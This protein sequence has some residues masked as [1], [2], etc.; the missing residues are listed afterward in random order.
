MTS[1]DYLVELFFKVD[2]AVRVDVACMH[3]YSQ[4]VPLQQSHRKLL[5]LQQVLALGN[6]FDFQFF[7]A[8]LVFEALLDGKVNLIKH[9]HVPVLFTGPV[10]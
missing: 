9:L 5:V 4:V 6:L 1:L 2:E 10:T 8:C 3:P 7:Q